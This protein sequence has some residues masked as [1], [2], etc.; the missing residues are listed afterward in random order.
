M[1]AISLEWYRSSTETPISDSAKVGR[2]VGREQEFRVALYGYIA[3][4]EKH[5]AV[6]RHMPNSG[7]RRPGLEFLSRP[8][9]WLSAR[10]AEKSRALLVSGPRRWRFRILRPCQQKAAKPAQ[11][12]HPVED[13]IGAEVNAEPLVY[14]GDHWLEYVDWGCHPRS[15]GA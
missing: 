8:F 11:S 12:G 15:I 9:D 3:N 6:A 14:T 7:I 13:T 2:K 4:Y 5:L 10:R 1:S